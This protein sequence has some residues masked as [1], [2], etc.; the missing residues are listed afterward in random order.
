MNLLVS[1]KCF[2]AQGTNSQVPQA[3]QCSRRQDTT[4]LALL[5]SSTHGPCRREYHVSFMPLSPSLHLCACLLQELPPVHVFSDILIYQLD[6]QSKYTSNY[7]IILSPVYL[8]F[9]TANYLGLVLLI[10]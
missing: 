9:Q 10:F 2:G 3:M 4:E 1:D 6:N 7:L 8:C 5:R